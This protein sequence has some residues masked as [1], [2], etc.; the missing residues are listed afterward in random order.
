MSI[1]TVENGS[2]GAICKMYTLCFFQIRSMLDPKSKDYTQT[3][4]GLIRDPF[5]VHPV[6]DRHKVC[7]EAGNVALDDNLIAT[8][9][10]GHS[11]IYSVALGGH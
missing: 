8:D 5:R 10:L 11:H 7:G 1:V 2:I 4:G 9:D 6:T 3:T